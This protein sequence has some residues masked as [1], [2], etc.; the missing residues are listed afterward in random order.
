MNDDPLQRLRETAWRR[1]LTSAEEAELLRLLADDVAAHADWELE[2]ALTGI[3]SK[4]PEPLAATN[5][6]AGV[7]ESVRAEQRL[8]A[9]SHRGLNAWWGRFGWQPKLAA[10]SGAM[11]I[12]V[13]VLVQHRLNVQQEIVAGVRA[14][15]PAA[16][17]PSVEWLTDFDAI[18]KLGQVPP[19]DDDLLAAL[20]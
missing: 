11:A 20:K 16:M 13:V 5:F 19:T 8:E 3:V 18:Q 15:T 14:L 9:R 10:L 6:T 12:V 1:K 7:M 4:L 2:L 17:V